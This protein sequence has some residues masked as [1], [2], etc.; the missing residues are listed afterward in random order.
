[1]LHRGGRYGLPYGQ[2]LSFAEITEA[3]RGEGDTVIGV[4]ADGRVATAC[5][6]N[7]R[8]VLQPDSRL[9]TITHDYQNALSVD[10]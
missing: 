7:D 10:G 2:P 6:K 3:V 8:F 1:M 9:V 4:L 5:A